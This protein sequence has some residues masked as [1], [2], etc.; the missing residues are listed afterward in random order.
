M[1]MNFTLAE[2]ATTEEGHAGRSD[3]AEDEER[4]PEA[5]SDVENGIRARSPFTR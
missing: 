5:E 2:G 3:G 1:A 4:D